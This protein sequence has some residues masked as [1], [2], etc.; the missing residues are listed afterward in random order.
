MTPKFTISP[1][2]SPKNKINSKFIKY[3]IKKKKNILLL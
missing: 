1:D 3:F 2:V